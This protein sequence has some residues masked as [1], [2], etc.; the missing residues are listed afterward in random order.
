MTS[1]FSMSYMQ[2]LFW[3]QMIIPYHRDHYTFMRL[4][5]CGDLGQVLFT[6]YYLK[7]EESIRKAMQHSNVVINLIGRQWETRNFSFEDVNIEGPARLARIARE[8]GVKRFIHI[9]D[10]NARENPKVR[11]SIKPNC[12]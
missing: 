12:A 9:S 1:N 10:I 5:V 7:D 8:M 11:Q 6:P 2:L 4:K 3:F